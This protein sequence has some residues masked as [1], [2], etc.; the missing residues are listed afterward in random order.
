MQKTL[1]LGFTATKGAIRQLVMKGEYNN[2]KKALP[3]INRLAEHC[4]LKMKKDSLGQ[5]VMIATPKSQMGVNNG[6]TRI[7][8]GI[9]GGIG[10][11]TEHLG[12]ALT[13]SKTPPNMKPKDNPIE[14]MAIWACEE[15][16]TK[17]KA[18]KYAAEA[19]KEFKTM[20]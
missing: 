13:K 12:S 7:F 5:V 18:K 2:Y 3:T 17:I 20:G 4:D 19:V 10:H 11:C 15:M 6:L 14:N 9:F 16:S 8:Y 1:G